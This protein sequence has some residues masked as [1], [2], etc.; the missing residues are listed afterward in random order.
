MSYGYDGKILRVDLSRQSF[1]I[2][3]P[4][5]KFYRQYMGG[6]GLISYYLLKDQKAKIDPFSPESRLIIAAGLM[7][8][9]PV[10]GTGRSVFGGKSP[11]TNAICSSEMGGFL[12][13]ELKHAGYDAVIIEG[14]AA[15]P[16]YLWI[17]NG[18][19]EIRDAAHLWGKIPAKP[20]I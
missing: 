11:L 3:E 7:T 16:V 9:T 14:R 18:Q 17:H 13:A 15:K 12:G 5:E 20:R 4:D 2:E 6:I 1:S 19:A 8:G 10:L